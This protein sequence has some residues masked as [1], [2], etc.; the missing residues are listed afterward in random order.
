MS[1]FDRIMG[2]NEAIEFS[3]DFE[4]LHETSQKAYIKKWALDTCINHIA[5]TISQTKFEIIDSE[6]KDTSSTTHYKL[7]VRPNTDE[8]A[9]T[10]WQKV[11]RKLIYDNEVLIVVT[12]SKDLIIA[13][14]FVR[15][16]YALYDDIFDHIMI[17][18]FEYE[19]SFRMSEVIYLE[20]NNESITNMLMGLFSDYG[21]IFGRMIKSNLMNNQIRATLAMDTSVSMKEES[22]Q[23]MQS[24]INKAYESFDKNDIAILPLQKGYEYK[25]HSS[26]N[27][28]KT[29]SQIEDMA[30]VPNQLLSYVARNLGIPVGLINGDTADIEAMTDNYMKFCIKPII[31]KITDELNAKL[32]SERGYKEGK[33]IKAISIDQKGPLEVSEA[34]DK[35]IAS[36]SFNRD[37][38]RVLTGFEPIG[39]E[40]M[41]KFIITKNYQT[42]DEETTGSE[43]GDI[44]GE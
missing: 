32:F 9:A 5:R 16:E 7:N 31:E 29:S 43:G 26:N 4:L 10:F 42:V 20:Y 3:Y 39:S 36:G 35:L 1:I 15:E 21:D 30:K 19:R 34:I 27:G 44:N 12:D 14:D 18:D 41:Q 8:S 6:S 2:R 17:G 24:F 28:A 25:E 13:D 33:R 37:E 22:Q 38:I 40:E 23:K 11:I